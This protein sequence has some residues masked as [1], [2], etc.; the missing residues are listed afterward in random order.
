MLWN[1]KMDRNTK[2]AGIAETLRKIL[3]D[4]DEMQEP[5]AAIKI[6][7]AISNLSMTESIYVEYR[8]V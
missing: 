1:G 3:S 2:L 4:L 8:E 6:A 5:L 7:E